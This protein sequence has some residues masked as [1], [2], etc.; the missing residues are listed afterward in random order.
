MASS[1]PPI[2][3]SSA[4]DND[5]NTSDKFS[6]WLVP[7]AIVN[8]FDIVQADQVGVE[9][10]ATSQSFGVVLE[11][12]HRTD[13]PSHLAN[14]ISNDFGTITS[15][16]PNTPRLGTTIAKCGV[17]NNDANVYMPIGNER[18][19][20][21]ANEAGIHL[22]LG[23]DTMP[24]ERRIPAGLIQMSN[25]TNAVAYF[26]RDYILGPEAAHVNIT[27]ISGLATKTSYA[28]FLLQSILQKT[29]ASKTAI[30]L[31][32]VKH[33]DL[34]MID[35][36]AEHLPQDQIDL[37][38]ALHLKPQPFENVHYFLPEGKETFRTGHPNSFVIPSSYQ[39]YGYSLVDASEILDLLFS[40]VIDKHDT[41]DSLIGLIME[42]IQRGDKKWADAMTW[43]GLLENEPLVK[44]GKPQPIGDVRAPSVGKFRRQARRIVTTRSSGLFVEQRR[45]GIVCLSEEIR[46]LRGGHTYVVDIARLQEE[47]QTLVFGDILRTIYELYA[48]VDDPD[49]K[50]PEKVIIFVDELNKYAPAYGGDSPIV[51]QVLDIAERG[52]SLGVILFSAQQFQSAVH[53]RVTGNA[54]TQVIGRV[55][56]AELASANYRSVD[57]EIKQNL[58][59]LPKGELVLIHSK[60]RKPLK[61]IFPKPAF[62]Q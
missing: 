19:I 7:H 48:E 44:E 33:G 55:G 9:S 53:Q 12:E 14:F 28:M 3:L 1:N 2:G 31:L 40:H 34:L 5:P 39:E 46:K 41:I 58:T 38:N 23:I 15:T 45:P 35:Q 24:E 50:L 43:R 54:G 36:A 18:I 59:R 21:F 29:D 37:W 27:G 11:L 56:A 17:L 13:A 49:A 32:N 6:F 26:D 51:R 22:A 10:G 25:G 52:R 20:R 4:T 8:P 57:D 30:I 42:G 47:E 62:R 60:F 61:V 16:P